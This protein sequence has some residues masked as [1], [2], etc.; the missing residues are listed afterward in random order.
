MFPTEP[1]RLYSFK[2]FE[3]ICSK[4]N[5]IMPPSEL[6]LSSQNGELKHSSQIGLREKKS[7][8]LFLRPA[9]YLIYPEQF[10]VALEICFLHNLYLGG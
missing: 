6:F 9:K 1:F 2:S 4:T 10:L 8:L 7:L 5:S 3:E